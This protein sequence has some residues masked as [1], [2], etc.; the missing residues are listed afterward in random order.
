[1]T[2]L[3]ISKS[4]AGLLSYD[5]KRSSTARYCLSFTK[6]S[7]KRQRKFL[8]RLMK[9]SGASAKPVVG[10]ARTT[11]R[12]YSCRNSEGRCQHAAPNGMAH[13]TKQA[14][15]KRPESDRVASAHQKQTKGQA[16]IS[17]LVS[18]KHFPVLIPQ[19]HAARKLMSKALSTLRIVESAGLPSGES[20]L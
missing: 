20:A 17:D 13:D 5:S 4:L 16:P 1:M 14:T 18:A 10:K 12:N 11:P 6:R 3:H 8:K 15:I 19:R 7:L 9:R 2:S